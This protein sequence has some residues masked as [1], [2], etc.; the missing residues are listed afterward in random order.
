MMRTVVFGRSPDELR[1]TRYTSRLTHHVS[2]FIRR[3]FPLANA[4]PVITR[5]LKAEARNPFSLRKRSFAIER[6]SA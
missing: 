4:W 3:P 1:I 2:R 6:A 5:E